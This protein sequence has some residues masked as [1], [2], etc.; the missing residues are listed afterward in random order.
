MELLDPL[1]ILT[2]VD[3]ATGFTQSV[4]ALRPALLYT[5]SQVANFVIPGSVL[6]EPLL[7]QSADEL[8]WAA[9]KLVVMTSLLA[10]LAYQV[11]YNVI[12]ARYKPGVF[13]TDIATFNNFRP[14]WCISSDQWLDR[15][16]NTF[17]ISQE[18]V[19]W[20]RKI[21]AR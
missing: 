9:V 5:L 8:V 4:E 20:C 11:L 18:N 7:L 1:Q 3:E 2:R 13:I 21:L 12:L 14:E 16:A 17:H 6:H 15:A 19:E 10:V